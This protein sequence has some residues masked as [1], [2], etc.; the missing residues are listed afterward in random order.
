MAIVSLQIQFDWL[1]GS[2]AA[3]MGKDP[4]AEGLDWTSVRDDLRARGILS[5]GTVSAALSWRDAGKLGYA[6]GP[7]VTMLCL[8]RDSR[9]FGFADAISRFAGQDVLVLI[10]EPPGRGLEA[11]KQWFTSVEELPGTAIR[12]GG[13]VLRTVIVL[14]GH[15]LQPPGPQ[16]G[17]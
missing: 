8:N 7:D 13:R 5:P 3:V 1:G 10:V 9:Q 17:G 6:L 4:T 11:A 16:S 2:L 12:L 15:G 14:R